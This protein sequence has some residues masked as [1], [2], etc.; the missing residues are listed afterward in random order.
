M[1]SICI[2]N[3]ATDVVDAELCVV[4]TKRNETNRKAYN[5][6]YLTQILVWP[7]YGTRNKNI[8]PGTHSNGV[9]VQNLNQ[10]KPSKVFYRYNRTTMFVWFIR[11]ALSLFIGFTAP[12][13]YLSTTCICL[14]FVIFAGRNASLIF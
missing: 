1:A 14:V 5:V 8:P 4:V 12:L 7:Q 10:F 2:C 6:S 13:P 9:Q 11:P 3:I